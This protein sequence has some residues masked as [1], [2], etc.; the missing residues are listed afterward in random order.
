MGLPIRDR[1]GASVSL[2]RSSA[3]IKEALSHIDE[4]VDRL[5]EEAGSDR[6]TENNNNG[7]LDPIEADGDEFE[8]EVTAA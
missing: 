7:Q 6:D 3:P 8:D 1:P 4:E 2:Y 5:D